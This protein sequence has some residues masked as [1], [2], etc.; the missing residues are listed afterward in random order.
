MGT[1]AHPCADPSYAKHRVAANGPQGRY[2]PLTR[3]PTA[4]LDR[5]SLLRVRQGRSGRK[6]GAPIEQKDGRLPV[7]LPARRI[8]FG[9]EKSAHQFQKSLFCLLSQFKSRFVLFLIAHHFSQ[10]SNWSGAKDLLS[11][12][13]ISTKQRARSVMRTNPKPSNTVIR[14]PRDSPQIPWSRSFIR[15]FLI[16]V[17]PQGLHRIRHYGLLASGTRAVNIARAREL[18]AVSKPEGGQ[19]TEAAVDHS[20]PDCPCCGGRMII[21]EVFERG[22]TPRHRPTGPIIVSRIDTS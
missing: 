21:I 4:I 15:R 12:L 1:E 9:S 22:A 5:R 17:L 10:S 20:K 11:P 3:W 16:H 18:L 6:D 14:T 2:A 8:D 19:P 13:S 7:V